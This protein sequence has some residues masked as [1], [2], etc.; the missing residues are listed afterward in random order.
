MAAPLRSNAKKH[1]FICFLCDNLK[2]KI[3]FFEL[4]P[5]PLLARV[6]TVLYINPRMPVDMD[7]ALHTDF[8]KSETSGGIKTLIASFVY[9]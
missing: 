2:A 1:F 5:R 7:G 6:R 9:L 4:K 8:I 3:I